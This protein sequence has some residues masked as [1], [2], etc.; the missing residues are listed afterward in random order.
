M[1]VENDNYFNSMLN[2]LYPILM[3][4][5][6]LKRGGINIFLMRVFFNFSQS[7]CVVF[8]IISSTINVFIKK[9]NLTL[10]F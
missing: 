9:N 10:N 4:F 7:F 1:V 3:V 2:V 8:S 6:P 5:I